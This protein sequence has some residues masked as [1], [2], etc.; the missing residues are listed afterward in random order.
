MNKT[1]RNKFNSL[2]QKHV[3][4][5]QRQGKADSTV[6]LSE[7]ENPKKWVLQCQHIGK[8]LPAIKYLSRYLYKGVISNH[9]IIA[10]DGKAC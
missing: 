5:L 6:G 2:Y 1:Q 9:N 4:A 7:P 3:S 10:N 8:G